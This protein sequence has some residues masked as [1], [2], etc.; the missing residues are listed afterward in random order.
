M[1]SSIVCAALAAAIVGTTP[2]QAFQLAHIPPNSMYII[3]CSNGWSFPWDAAGP[4][5]YAIM[6]GIATGLCQGT[7]ILR[8]NS[9]NARFDISK[10]DGKKL[11]SEQNPQTFKEFPA[12]AAR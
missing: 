3:L 10:I 11:L 5:G 9:P 12:P 7:I 2:V 8:P 6:L 1:K 4:N